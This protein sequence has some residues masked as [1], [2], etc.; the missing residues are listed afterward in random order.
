MIMIRVI[1][2]L[3]EEY[4]INP[5]CDKKFIVQVKGYNGELI[6][7][8]TNCHDPQYFGTNRQNMKLFSYLKDKIVFGFLGQAPTMVLYSKDM[9]DTQIECS[10]QGI[11]PFYT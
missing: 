1:D 6:D 7:V 5:Y 10:K 8:E 9:Y 4:P 2:D 11:Y 3:Y